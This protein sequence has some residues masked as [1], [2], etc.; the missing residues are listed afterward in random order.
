MTHNFS[1]QWPSKY[2]S[3]RRLNAVLQDGAIG[4][5]RK[6]KPASSQ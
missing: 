1:R 4:N 6:H 5:N 2:P 3:L